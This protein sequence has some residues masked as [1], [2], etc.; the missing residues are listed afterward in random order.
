MESMFLTKNAS[1]VMDAAGGSSGGGSSVGDTFSG[2]STGVVIIALIVA[3]IITILVFVLIVE[4]K[5]APRSR[6]VK[7]LREYLNFRS[8]LISGIIKFV[9]LFLAVLLTIMS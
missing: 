9:Y 1:R 6:F 3:L 8:I 5:K 7:W 2:V 4:K